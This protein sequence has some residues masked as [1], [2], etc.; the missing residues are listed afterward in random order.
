MVTGQVEATPKMLVVDDDSA[1]AESIC[2][3]LGVDIRLLREPVNAIFQ[4]TELELSK[5]PVDGPAG[6]SALAA[7]ATV[8]EHPND[9]A[10][11]RQ[12][13]PEEV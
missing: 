2:D 3:S 9:H 12:E 11:L 6:L 4:I 8:V 5:T 1:F 13:L 7:G 10:V